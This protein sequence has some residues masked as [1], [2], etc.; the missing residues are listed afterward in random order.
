[1]ERGSEQTYLAK[2]REAGWVLNHSDLGIETL[3]A[4]VVVAVPPS[5]SFDAHH[6]E[7][8]ASCLG[9]RGATGARSSM[10]GFGPAKAF[11]IFYERRSK[12]VFSFVGLPRN[13]G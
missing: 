1:M 13:H 11:E 9:H 7:G 12:S 10:F 4:S 8:L 5:C 6:T 3:L 2:R